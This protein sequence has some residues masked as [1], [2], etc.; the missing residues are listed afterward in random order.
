LKEAVGITQLR[1][2]C[3]ATIVKKGTIGGREDLVGK[4]GVAYRIETEE[5]LERLK[6][7]YD[8]PWTASC[9]IV[10]LRMETGRELE[11]TRMFYPVGDVGDFYE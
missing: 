5:E 7:H 8:H 9:Y 1:D 10:R 2:E 4:E 6:V 11:E 3:S